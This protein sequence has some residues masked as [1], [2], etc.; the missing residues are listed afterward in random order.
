MRQQNGSG[1]SQTP[2]EIPG[3]TIF[4]DDVRIV[5]KNFVWI[6]ATVKGGFKWRNYK[7]TIYKPIEA[8]C[9]FSSFGT[10][11]LYYCLCICLCILLWV[12]LSHEISSSRIH[13]LCRHSK[14]SL[15][16][17]TAESRWN[18]LCLVKFCGHFIQNL[19]AIL[20]PL[21]DFIVR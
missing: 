2:E 6:Q 3:V 11:I 16:S 19:S 15:N 7:T 12:Y 17:K 8:I 9:Q 10:C 20:R 4:Y 14:E 18:W 5:S 1:L 13:K 21:N